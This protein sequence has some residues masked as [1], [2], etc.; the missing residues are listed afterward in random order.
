MISQLSPNSVEICIEL[1]IGRVKYPLYMYLNIWKSEKIYK[2][3]FVGIL[4]L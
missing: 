1:F 3:L 4:Y 2:F